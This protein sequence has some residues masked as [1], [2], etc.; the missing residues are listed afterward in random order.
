M[1]RLLGE[2]FLR[3]KV[4]PSEQRRKQKSAAGLNLKIKVNLNE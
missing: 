4:V 3:R 2:R 1:Y